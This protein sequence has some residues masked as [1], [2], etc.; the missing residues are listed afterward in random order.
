MPP[1]ELL[2]RTIRDKSGKSFDRLWTAQKPQGT[3]GPR[4]EL[5]VFAA[6][7]LPFQFCNRRKEDFGTFRNVALLMLIDLETTCAEPGGNPVDE[8]RKRC[9]PP[10]LS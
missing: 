10:L 9:L 7:R 8:I 2:R 6:L 3:I 4:Q 1:A 5:Q